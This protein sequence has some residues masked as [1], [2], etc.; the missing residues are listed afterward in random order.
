ML[1]EKTSLGG[2]LPAYD[3][4]MSL[5]IVGSIPFESDDVVVKMVVLEK[6]NERCV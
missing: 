4:R 3:G 5:S 1:H 6:D 2:K